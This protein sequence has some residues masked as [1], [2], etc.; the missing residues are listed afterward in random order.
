MNLKDAREGIDRSQTNFSEWPLKK[1]YYLSYQSHVWTRAR[2]SP[3]SVHERPTQSRLLVIRLATWNFR[4]LWHWK[5]NLGPVDVTCEWPLWCRLIEGI[6]ALITGKDQAD[7]LRNGFVKHTKY[8]SVFASWSVIRAL[9]LQFDYI[10]SSKILSLRASCASPNWFG[11]GNK[12]DSICL[13]DPRITY[14]IDIRKC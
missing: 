13:W 1:N 5:E 12:T 2:V 9:V 10:I 8:H 6:G 3:R 4:F 7:A 14:A 11:D